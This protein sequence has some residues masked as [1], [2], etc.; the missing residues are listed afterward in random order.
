MRMNDST[1]CMRPLH[2]LTYVWAFGWAALFLSLA[3]S[4]R[5]CA[6]CI[7]VRLSIISTLPYVPSLFHSL[8][9]VLAH[10]SL[11][12]F[13]R[14]HTKRQLALKQ[15][16]YWTCT[17]DMDKLLLFR[18]H[19]YTSVT[20]YTQCYRWRARERE[21]AGIVVNGFVVKRHWRQWYEH[22]TKFVK[23]RVWVTNR[24]REEKNHAKAK[25]YD[26]IFFHSSVWH[27]MYACTHYLI[28]CRFWMHPRCSR[29]A[30]ARY[31]HA[32]SRSGSARA[33]VCISAHCT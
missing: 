15:K 29:T 10:R 2:V 19:T 25:R 30:I 32:P 31:K 3:L 28:N 27:N 12:R 13:V 24:E 23:W 16:L 22:K 18:I 20:Y 17:S 5:L 4:L 1:N 9:A 33:V 11:I 21:R 8:R 14:M 6:S 26:T 7:Y